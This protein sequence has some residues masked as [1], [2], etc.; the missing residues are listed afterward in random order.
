M[1]T[2][3]AAK[4]SLGGKPTPKEVKDGG[5]GTHSKN[6]SRA[7]SSGLNTKN[8]SDA[9]KTTVAASIVTT[10]ASSNGGVGATTSEVFRTEMLN[11]FLKTPTNTEKENNLNVQ[12][13]RYFDSKPIKRQTAISQ[14][15]NKTASSGLFNEEG[16]MNDLK[17]LN[18]GRLYR[19]LY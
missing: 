19:Y 11:Y 7:N 12:N 5:T 3:T 14:A 13:Q 6:G 15:I 17:Y 1:S 9:M 4:S 16:K 18:G 8:A 10:T 2:S